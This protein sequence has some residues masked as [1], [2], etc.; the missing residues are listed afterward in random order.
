MLIAVDAGKHSTKA[1]SN[2]K[3]LIYRTKLDDYEQ[4]MSNSKIQ[5]SK[6]YNIEFQGKNYLLGD[7]AITTDYDSSKTKLCHK[8]S[9]YLSCCKLYNPNEDV[10]IS[11]GCPLTQFKESTLKEQYK[12]YILDKKIIELKIDNEYH[13]L[14]ISDVLVFPE[15]SGY[16]YI[17]M[18]AYLNQIVGIVD[19]GGQNTN[20]SVYERLKPVA[21]TVFSINEGGNIINAKIKRELNSKLEANYQDYEIPYVINNPNEKEKPII[22]R[23]S[24]EQLK[25]IIEEMKKYNWNLNSIPIVF[26]GGGSALFNKILREYLPTAIISPNAIWDNAKGYLKVGN[27]VCQQILK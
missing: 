24:R 25:L 12:N 19:I 18:Q 3:T 21:S 17:N 9:I 1:L 22:E 13:R 4:Q 11:T 8:L 23:I 26:T 5:N 14:R 7:D 27:M 20:A 10:V 2:D 15:S 16:V 6:T